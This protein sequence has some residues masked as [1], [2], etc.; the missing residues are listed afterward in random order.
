MFRK[1]F[2]QAADG[3]AILGEE[4]H[5]PRPYHSLDC[6]AAPAIRI[7]VPCKNWMLRASQFT[8]PRM[9]QDVSLAKIP[10]F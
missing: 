7:T 2:L 4:T 5:L 1:K 8:V 6:F 9:Q 10:C 3:P